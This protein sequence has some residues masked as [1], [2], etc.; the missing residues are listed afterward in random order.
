M[1]YREIRIHHG[2]D[3]FQLEGQLFYTRFFYKTIT[4]GL[5][6]FALARTVKLKNEYIKRI[7]RTG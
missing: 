7:S 6:C 2:G 1:E 4:T 5:S 3:S